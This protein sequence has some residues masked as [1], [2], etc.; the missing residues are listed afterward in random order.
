[1][2][3]VVGPSFRSRTSSLPVDLLTYVSRSPWAK[4][5]ALIK[6]GRLVAFLIRVSAATPAP[7]NVASLVGCRRQTI[8]LEREKDCC[9][10]FTASFA[11]R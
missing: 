1:M 3:G 11:T 2:S 4:I 10:L 8:R 7:V 6:I 5:I 9:S